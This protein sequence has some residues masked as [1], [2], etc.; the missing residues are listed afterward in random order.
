MALIKS[1]IN[2][3]TLIILILC[4]TVTFGCKAI[5][6]QNNSSSQN[7]SSNN[8][9]SSQPKQSSSNIS[10]QIL[11]SSSAFSSSAVNLGYNITNVDFLT[12]QLGYL[13]LNI[14]NENSGKIEYY[15]FFK[16]TNGDKGGLKLEQK[17]NY[18]QQAFT[19]ENNGYGLLDTKGNYNQYSWDENSCSLVET[20]NGGISWNQ[21]DFFKDKFVN[22][23]K[24]LNSNII[25][26]SA[27]DS[28]WTSNNGMMPVYHL[29]RTIDGGTD[30]EVINLPVGNVGFFTDYSW[31]SSQ[32]GYVLFANEPGAGGQN[33]ALYYTN[34]GGNKWSLKSSTGDGNSVTPTGNIPDTGYCEGIDFLSNGIVYLGLGRGDI[35]KSV[36]GG[37]NFSSVTV[38]N[39]DSS[40]PVPDFINYNQGFSVL[41]YGSLFY[42]S[43]SG[44]DWSLI[45][46]NN[47]W[48]T[49]L[50]A[51]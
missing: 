41:N 22:S 31:I 34:D 5:S 47:Y 26:V 42:T 28:T 23:V 33:K 46:L 4:T 29:Y 8:N 10:S 6:Q 7:I 2:L 14:V 16:T 48:E 45:T 39:D 19:N 35:N 15:L 17:I 11:Q 32:E 51:E 50:G 30:W 25:F 21:V 13:C 12:T 38:S 44:A 36:D 9:I 43:D 3:Y 20:N 37:I 24:A 27:S 1:K 18:A 49:F 40:H